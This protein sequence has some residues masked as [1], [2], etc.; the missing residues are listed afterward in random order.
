MYLILVVLKHTKEHV[1]ERDEAVHRVMREV[2]VPYERKLGNV[3]VRVQ[4]LL[5]VL[6]KVVIAAATLLRRQSLI[7]H[8]LLRRERLT[9]SS[10]VQ[11]LEGS[12]WS[13]VNCWTALGA[14]VAYRI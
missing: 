1:V 8:L 9:V 10:V 11:Q 5:K 14:M 6:G 13:D 2:H 4:E 7:P 12:E 3:L